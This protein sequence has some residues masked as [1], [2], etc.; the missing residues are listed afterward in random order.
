MTEATHA[1]GSGPPGAQWSRSVTVVVPTKNAARTLAACLASVR[2]QT[3]PCR[4]VVVDNGS[5]DATV[6]I[7]EWSADVLLHRA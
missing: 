2:S 4:A 5:T 7:D 6:A 1:E 3:Y